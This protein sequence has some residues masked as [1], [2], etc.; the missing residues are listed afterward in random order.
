MPTRKRPS[1]SIRWVGSANPT[2]LPRPGTNLV[3]SGMDLRTT[4]TLMRHQNLASTA[5]Y[6]QVFDSKRVEA[7]DRLNID[8]EGETR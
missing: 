6:T 4:Q 8:T 1:R 5:I 3:L 2:M 7:I